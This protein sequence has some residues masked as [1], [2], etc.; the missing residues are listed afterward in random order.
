MYGTARFT[1]VTYHMS[2][3]CGFLAVL[4]IRI[5]RIRMFWGLADPRPDPLVKSTDPAPDPSIIKQK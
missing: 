4:G 5:R 3:I 2:Q 1:A